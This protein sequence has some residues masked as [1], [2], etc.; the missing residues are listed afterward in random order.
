MN[1]DLPDGV[2]SGTVYFKQEGYDVEHAYTVTEGL[3]MLGGTI[4]EK[5]GYTSHDNYDKTGGISMTYDADKTTT[6]QEYNTQVVFDLS[7]MPNGA[8]INDVSWEFYADPPAA[9]YNVSI[10]GQKVTEV[11]PGG[12]Y[13]LPTGQGAAT[14]GYLIDGAQGA[15]Q[16]VYKPGATKSNIQSDINF[17]SVNSVT[18]QV[19]EGAAMNLT[20]KTNVVLHSKAHSE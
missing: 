6:T 20:T 2:S 1:V 12:S 14:V 11:Q 4:S 9:T 5:S 17:I 16:V 15:E 3:N 18:A 10:D 8:I 19:A 7:E 13:T